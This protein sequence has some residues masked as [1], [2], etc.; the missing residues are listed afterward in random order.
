MKS[1]KHYIFCISII[2]S[3]KNFTT[4]IR[5]EEKM[6]MIRNPETFYFDFG[7]PKHVDENLKH[8]TEFIIQN[9][10]SLA[11][12]KQKTRLTYYCPN[13]SMKTIFMNTENSKRNEPHNFFLNIS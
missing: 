4:I 13:I 10:E 9:N 3:P 11:E 1:D 12:N 8:K 6:I 7:W 2:Q 5:M